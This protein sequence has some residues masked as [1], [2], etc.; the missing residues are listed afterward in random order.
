MV[1]HVA[2]ADAGQV[3]A[4][5][6]RRR[7]HGGEFLQSSFGAPVAPI[8]IRQVEQ[9]ALNAESG[10]QRRDLRAHRARAD[11]GRTADF[12]AIFR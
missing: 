10:K 9:L 6:E 7:A 12:K 5:E 1:L 4:L 2:G 3:G 8:G 11:Y